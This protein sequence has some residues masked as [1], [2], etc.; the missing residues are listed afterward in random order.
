METQHVITK[1]QAL[2]II[3]DED[4]IH[5]FSNDHASMFIG[6]DWS[7]ESIIGL[8]NNA[9]EIEIG[10]PACREMKHGICV[11]EKNKKRPWFVQSPN[12]E[13]FLKTNKESEKEN[14]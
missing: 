7:R 14:E 2:E 6:C 1:E 3:G 9:N 5:V 8:L 4:Q 13:T 10:G 11:W 12:L